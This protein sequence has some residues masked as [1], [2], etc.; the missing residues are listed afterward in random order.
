MKYTLYDVGTPPL[1]PV[2]RPRKNRVKG[3]PRYR[4]SILVLK[5]Q[6]EEFTSVK[7]QLQ[8][9]HLNVFASFT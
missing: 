1:T 6:N 2:L 7:L 8:T 4:R 9:L 3:N 5:P